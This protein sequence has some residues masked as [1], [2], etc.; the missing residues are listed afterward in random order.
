M[1]DSFVDDFL[2]SD[3]AIDFVLEKSLLL[4]TSL[5]VRLFLNYD[6]FTYAHQIYF[7]FFSS[8]L[9]TYLVA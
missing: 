7:V 4:Y 9:R 5:P 1:L 6:Q 2:G 3:T 8:I